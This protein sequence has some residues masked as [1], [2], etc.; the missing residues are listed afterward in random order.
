[1]EAIQALRSKAPISIPLRINSESITTQSTVPQFIPSSH[2]TT[3]ASSSQASKE[4]VAT[5]ISSALA[6]K[7]AWESAPFA[8]RAAVF[9]KAAELIS[10][11]YRPDIMAATILGQGKNAWQAEIDAST[12]LVDFLRF[13]VLYAEDLYKQQPAKNAPGVWKCACPSTMPV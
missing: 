1:M 9:L 11:K 12:E 8:D 2:A 4:Q 5:A 6:A 13:N 10:G 7:S 3:L